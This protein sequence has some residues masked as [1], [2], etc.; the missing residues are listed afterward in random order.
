MSNVKL[1]VVNNAF[2]YACDNRVCQTFFGDNLF[3]VV[4]SVY[5][6]GLPLNTYL[7]YQ[8]WDFDHDVTPK[9]ETDID[10][11]HALYQQT[12]GVFYLVTYPSAPALP[13][14]GTLLLSI[15]VS[16]AVAFLMPMPKVENTNVSEPPSPN[17]ALSS[18]TNRQ[19]LG[20]RV[21]D[22]FGEVWAVPD[23]LAPSYSVYIDNQEIEF[24]YFCLGIGRYDVKKC[25]DDTTPINQIRGATALVFNPD[26]S[27]N[28]TPDFRFGSSFSA[29]EAKFANL[30]VKRY[31]AVNGQVLN[32]PDDYLT[33]DVM[34]QSPNVLKTNSDTTNFLTMFQVGDSV[35]VEKASDLKSGNN[36]TNDEKL[37][38]YSLNGTYRVQSVSSN[39]IVL[40]DVVSVNPDW[41]KLMDNQDFTQTQNITV[42]TE[43]N[44]LWQ[45][46]FYTDLPNHTDV[47]LNL[48]APNGIY[49]SYGD[50][51][52]ALRIYFDIESELVD[53]VG[54]PIAGTTQI[55]SVYLQSPSY[56]KYLDRQGRAWV[57]TTDDN[58]RRS[59]YTTVKIGNRHF[60]LG[61]RLRFRI[62]RSTRKI[63]SNKGQVLQEIKLSDFYGIAPI[64]STPKGVTT[65]YTKTVATEGALAIKERK[66]KMLVQ[67]YIR[68][69]QDNDNLML[70][71]RI[72][73]VIYHLATDDK[74]GNLPKNQLNMAQIKAEID[75]QI[76]YFGTAKTAEFCGTF[77][78]TNITT[79]EMIQTVAQAGFCQAY[80]L[81]NQIH[82][83]FEKKQ[84][85][86]MVQF[87]AHNILPDSFEYS[88]SF[89]ARNDYDG[90]QVTYTDPD[91]DAKIT[92]SYPQSAINPQKLDLIGV[93][94]KVQAHFH[95]M[96]THYKNQ[97]AYKTCEFTGADESGLVIPTN[98]IDVADLLSADSVGGVVESLDVVRGKTVLGVSEPIGFGVGTAC[99]VFVQTT[100]GVVDNIKCV[101]ADSYHLTL[102]RPPAY[103]LSLNGV[104]QATYKLINHSEYDRDSYIVTSKD[105][106]SNALSYKLSCINYTDKYYQSDDDFKKNLISLH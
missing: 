24:S 52:S 88:E 35:L 43:N 67:R 37:I 57:R 41:Q 45:G 2:E 23:L 31:T 69:W 10:K 25:Y 44:T 98:R 58:V 36:L 70:S 55:K 28:D 94:N 46:W 18:R 89:G 104:V 84:D 13:M 99:T 76:A 34:F 93:R 100:A 21:P 32:P 16:V 59:A 39:Q 6:K 4:Q 5:P 81:N 86:S 19:R 66:L 48:K 77:D 30:A 106:G 80:R 91:D 72:D 7:Y 68:N 96:R 79:E 90:V 8:H 11:L 29:D 27:V 97:L 42:S 61:K 14:L 12:Q 83:H 49:T 56:E 51:W 22:I 60:G 33:A 17:N 50:E 40:A 73:D 64:T 102:S 47:M 101:V 65:V 53:S 78:T 63:N 87:N 85:F 105:N 62:R 103:P 92:L 9:N 26:K 71:N 15:A 82:V 38:T 1:I 20:G 74:I 95:L 3:D 54:N 75:Q